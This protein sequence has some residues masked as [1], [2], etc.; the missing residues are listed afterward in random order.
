MLT[1]ANTIVSYAFNLQGKFLPFLALCLNYFF[2]FIT[3]IWWW[4]KTQTPWWIQV[5]VALCCFGGDVVGIFAYDYTSLASA[6]LLSTT[7][8]FWIAPLAFFVFHR[9]IN[10]WQFL[11]MILAVVGVSMVMVAQGVEG[12]RLKGNLLALL[13]AVFY[14]CSTVLQE[15]LVK[16]ESV[17]TYLLSISTPDFPLTGILAGA[18]EWKQIRDYSWD[19]KGACLLFGY[20]IVLSIY[21]M[22]CPVVMQHSNATVMNISL[23]TSNFY[24][25]FIDIFAFKSKASWIYL[26]GFVCIPAA[27]LLYVL[28]EPKPGQ[29]E[30]KPEEEQ[31]L[32]SSSNADQNEDDEEAI[33]E[34][35]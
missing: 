26:V 22:V 20:S 28:T 32:D 29:Q 10:W 3:N 35:L 18:L 24:S 1:G 2:I 34:S 8:I 31:R 14:A 33:V 7:V 5:L 25:L 21:Y 13:S 9:K 19:A 15:K 27:I 4:P 23:L 30:V 6:M 12:S 16:D 17:H 11:A